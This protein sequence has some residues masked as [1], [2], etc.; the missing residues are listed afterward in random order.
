MN[1]IAA[2]VQFL[3][4]LSRFAPQLYSAAIQ[5]VGMPGG[6]GGLFDGGGFS[7]TDQSTWHFDP[8]TSGGGSGTIIPVSAPAGGWASSLSSN[9]GWWDKFTD[10]LTNIGTAVVTV[11]GQDQL[12]R[13]NIERARQGLAPISAAQAGVQPSVGVDVR[14]STGAAIAAGLVAAAPV[15][16]LGGVVLLLSSMKKKG[17]RR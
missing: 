11:R 10:A 17:K 14:A 5:D 9:S 15:L 13:L 6:L 16:A 7:L 3:N 8:A 12:V 1:V 4:W 2:R